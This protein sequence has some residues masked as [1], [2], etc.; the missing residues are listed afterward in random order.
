MK[1][2]RSSKAAGQSIVLIAVLIVVLVAFVGLSVDVAHTYAEQRR[3]QQAANAAALAG[4]NAVATKRTNATVQADIQRALAANGIDFNAATQQ[5]RFESS[6]V[7]YGD[8]TLY[9][10]SSFNQSATPNNVERVVVRVEERVDTY[11]ARVIG[12]RDLPAIADGYGCIGPYNLGV[13]PVGIPMTL[14]TQ[15]YGSGPNAQRHRKFR[16]WVH[17]RNPEGQGEILPNASGSDW[18]NWHT[19]VD[20]PYRQPEYVMIPIANQNEGLPGI[21]NAWLTWESGTNSSNATLDAALWFPGSLTTGGTTFTEV[22]NP[23]NGSANGPTPGEM[24]INDWTDGDTGARA[25]LTAGQSNPLGD[26]VTRRNTMILP[27][28]SESGTYGGG[29]GNRAFRIGKM[30]MF[31]LVDAHLQGNGKFIVLE[32]LGESNGSVVQC[33]APQESRSPTSTARRVVGFLRYD[34]LD[35]TIQSNRTADIVLLPSVSGNM[36]LSMNSGP[37]TARKDLVAANMRDFA[38]DVADTSDGDGDPENQMAVVSYGNSG[39]GGAPYGTWSSG[40]KDLTITE[41]DTITEA[42]DAVPGMVRAGNQRPGWTGLDEANRLLNNG[43]RSGVNKHVVMVVDGVMNVCGYASGA[44]GTGQPTAQF[45]GAFDNW[46][47]PLTQLNGE[48]PL[49]QAQNRAAAMRAA[50]VIIHVVALTEPDSR[51]SG[52]FNTRGLRDISSGPGYYYEVQDEAQLAQAF[53]DIWSV[54]NRGPSATGHSTQASCNPSSQVQALAG[55]RVTLYNLNGTPA[56]PQVITGADGSFIIDNVNPGTYTLSVSSAQGNGPPVVFG[57][58]YSR[59]FNN[60]NRAQEG[61]I[62]ISVSPSGAAITL[63][64]RGTEDNHLPGHTTADVG[65]GGCR[66]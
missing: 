36:N 39:G 45:N 35:R 17:G 22:A 30:G 5:Y 56:R 10:I 14:S 44:C 62:P 51:A 33:G 37:G 13:Y 66:P 63:L 65:E 34:R 40:W 15:T 21:H 64:L 23:P 9:P 18:T 48:W 38:V 52:F 28:Y 47:D 55:A 54:V 7:L 57:R 49:W 53:R 4:M 6:Y 59:T 61:D 42:I 31:R 8:S 1:T 29:N 46:S 43:A 20:S 58:T 3:V 32:Y 41:T 19:Y 16:S 12:R 24:E 27:M 11:F 26:H 2:R 50:G 25:S 60:D